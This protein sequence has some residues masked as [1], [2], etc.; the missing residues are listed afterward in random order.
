MPAEEEIRYVSAT[1]DGFIIGGS[2][3]SKDVRD[4]NVQ[5]LNQF[6]SIYHKASI[7]GN[8]L[9]GQAEVGREA[10]SVEAWRDHRLN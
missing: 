6:R 8:L 5:P 9:Q 3:L 7:R 4:D 1:P 2:A 10:I